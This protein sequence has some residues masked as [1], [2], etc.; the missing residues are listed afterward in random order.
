MSDESA[1]AV[2]RPVGTS[3][4]RR[5]EELVEGLD[6]TVWEMDVSSGTFTYV[7]RRAE[8]ML[9]Y[10]VERWLTEPGFWSDVLLHRGD[11]ERA[12][13][14]RTRAAREARDHVLEYRVRAADGRTLWLRDLV[15]A[16]AQL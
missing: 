10:P 3:D 9:G 11:R 2:A 6:A 4:G 16:E 1:T 12:L 5:F 15:R 14:L 7:S 13:E 8:E